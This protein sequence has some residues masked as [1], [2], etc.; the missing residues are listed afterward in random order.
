M[1]IQVSGVNV[2]DNERNINV[3]VLTA[4]SVDVPPEVLTFSPTDASSDVALD[5]NIVITF[6]VSVIKGSGSII[7]REGSASGTAIETIAVSSGQVTISG[8]AVTLNPS[9]DLPTGKDIYVVVPEGAF[10]HEALNSETNAINTYN[11]ST[12]PVVATGFSPSDGA[13]DVDFTSN[14]VITFNENITKGSSGNITIRQ[15]SSIG[16]IDQQIS[17]TSGNVSVSGNQATINPPSDIVDDTNVF[18]VVDAG[19]FRNADGDEASENAVISTYD[20]TTAPSVPP[21]GSAFEGG[22]VVRC[23]GGFGMGCITIFSGSTKNLVFKTRRCKQS[24]LCHGMFSLVFVKQ[25]HY[26]FST[27]MQN[28]LGSSNIGST[29]LER[30]MVLTPMDIV[31][32]SLTT[33]RGQFHSLTKMLIITLERSD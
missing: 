28:I 22:Y 33:A 9:S 32:L 10:R 21:L 23:T 16:T 6:N 19:C 13:T 14:I 26:V 17:V 27:S 8:A 3:G 18:I 4:T 24:N 15:G 11:F 7:L 29:L 2:I 5:T 12:G 20:F 25:K 31:W 1:A 30:L